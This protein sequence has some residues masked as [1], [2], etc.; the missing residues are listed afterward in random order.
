M[1][2]HN[3]PET[4]DAVIVQMDAVVDLCAAEQSKLGYFAVLYRNVTVCVRDAVA[5]GRFDDPA[6]MQRLDVIFANRYL[7][8][9]AA[10]R[11]GEAPT[12]SWLV[13]FQ[14]ARTWSPIVLQHLLLGM[15]AHINLDLG[16]AAAE[17]APGEELQA[18]KHDFMEITVLLNAMI[19]AM[20][21]RIEQISPWFRL[22]DAAGGRVNE[23][24]CGFGIAQAR[25]LAWVFAERL[26]VTPTDQRDEVIA[27]QDQIV[28]LLARVVRS[29]VGLRL[30]LALLLILLRETR[31][32]RQ[33]MEVLRMA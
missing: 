16:I 20:E 18:L 27:Q 10:Y 26:A 3:T 13:A 19:E 9:L 8:A 32:V 28:T 17:V 30:R 25:D 23:T 22:I 2:T 11:R 29:P 5:A 14:A 12:Q 4:I 15:N 7:D 33:V 31:N 21:T 6:R 1:Q 24:L